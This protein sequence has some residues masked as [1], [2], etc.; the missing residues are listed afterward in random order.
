MS[1]IADYV[2]NRCLPKQVI[3]DDANNDFLLKRFIDV[4][5]EGGLGD[6][7]LLET[8]NILQLMDPKTMPDKFLTFYAQ[9]VGYPWDYELPIDFQRRV[10]C[11]WSYIVKR[12]GSLPVLKYLCKE[13]A[14]AETKIKE[15]YTAFRTFNKNNDSYYSLTYGSLGD[16]PHYIYGNYEGSTER[17][18]LIITIKRDDKSILPKEEIM[19]RFLQNFVPP[20]VHI[21][22]IYSYMYVEDVFV[23]I[24]EK[25]K[26]K[27][28][29]YDDFDVSIDIETKV[30]NRITLPNI[31][32]DV[33]QLYP[34]GTAT[35][36]ILYRLNTSFKTNGY[37]HLY[38]NIIIKDA[39][40]CA[41]NLAEIDYLCKLTLGNEN[42]LYYNM[43]AN[44][45]TVLNS[46][47]KLNGSFDTLGFED[48]M[49]EDINEINIKQNFNDEFT[50]VP[51][52]IG[53]ELNK[54]YYKT[55]STMVTNSETHIDRI[56]RKG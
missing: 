55:N 4:I 52:P 6:E 34:N 2:Y 26:I 51:N 17:V 23:V 9:S 53:A 40:V 44:G 3:S 15:T 42:D 7:L 43:K 8:K 22:I 20:Y 41:L 5:C 24:E 46:S 54:K 19:Q 11:N 18:T 47:F 21:I 35:N 45:V 36:G 16:T 12:K 50:L 30:D 27:V 31:H 33:E 32:Y 28:N 1:I 48:I 13:L 29:L 37:Y 38:D 56:V 39:D 49:L 14:L 25:D 10:L